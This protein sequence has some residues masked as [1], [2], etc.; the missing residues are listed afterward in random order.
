MV[1]T[2]RAIDLEPMIRDLIQRMELLAT[3]GEFDM[4]KETRPVN[5]GANVVALMPK[6]KRLRERIEQDAPF[7]QLSFKELG[8]R[9]NIAPLLIRGIVDIVFNIRLEGRYDS[10]LNYE[11]IS[12]D[13]LMCFYDSSTR[14]A[15]R[16]LEDYAMSNHAVIDFGANRR[17]LVDRT[18]EDMGIERRVKTSMPSVETL[19]YIIKDSTLVATLPSQVYESVLSHLD[20]VEPPMKMPTLNVD[21][22]WHR[23]NED[24]PRSKWIRTILREI[25]AEPAPAKPLNST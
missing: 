1:P 2:G 8:S 3:A 19:G 16:T 15:P 21:M 20:M 12:T 10:Q 4:S 24:S 6:V 7:C 22:I 11:R 14:D 5:I 18:L 17:S 9:D 23:R 25:A 13:R